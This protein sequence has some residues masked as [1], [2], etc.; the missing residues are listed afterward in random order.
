MRSSF[1]IVAGIAGVLAVVSLAG[2]PAQAAEIG[3][4]GIEVRAGLVNIESDAGSTI[5]FSGT[6]DL[7]TLAENFGLEAGVDFW[8]K[9]WG[10]DIF[11]ESWDYT[12]TNIGFLGTVRYEFP[13]EGDFMPFAFGGLG[14]HLW[15]WSLDYD[16]P[17]SEWAGDTDGSDLEFGF[18]IGAGAEL[19]L[20]ESMN[21]AARGG[22]NSNG[23]AD[24]LFIQGGVKFLMGQ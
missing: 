1:S 4:E 6:A 10:E 18:H 23:G 3:L 19:P 24:Y 22:F 12:W 17:Y 8:T 20:S 14:L 21:F 11:G 9:N 16:G 13:V 5:G 15:N 2:A 7:G